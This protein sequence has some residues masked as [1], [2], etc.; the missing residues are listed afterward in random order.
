MGNKR[1]CGARG[2]RWGLSRG[3]SAGP[4]GCDRGLGIHGS[5]WGLPSCDRNTPGNMGPLRSEHERD[6]GHAFG[7]SEPLQKAACY[8]CSV[9][10]K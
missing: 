8:V 2:Q 10:F 9:L 6:T 1:K 5:D 4:P 3:A 7:E